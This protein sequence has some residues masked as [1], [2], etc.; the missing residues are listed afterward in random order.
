MD[1]CIDVRQE[2][3]AWGHVCRYVCGGNAHRNMSAG[4]GRRD[5]AHRIDTHA[6]ICPTEY[7]AVDVML[8]AEK[9]I[10]IHRRLSHTDIQGIMAF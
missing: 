1:P 5:G 3:D 7:L 10:G 9:F 4:M 2:A 8:E 6:G